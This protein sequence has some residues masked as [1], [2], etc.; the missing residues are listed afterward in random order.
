MAEKTEEVVSRIGTIYKQAQQQA[1]AVGH[2]SV[3]IDQVSNVVQM[4]SATSEESA[5]ASE[6]LSGQA[7]VLKSLVGQ[8]Q[9]SE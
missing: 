7:A 2:V 1:D 4:N 3:G 5:A 6:E 8:F 9:L